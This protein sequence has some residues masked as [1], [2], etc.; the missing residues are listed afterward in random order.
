MGSGSSRISSVG[1]VQNG[2]AAGGDPVC[3]RVW[4][5]EGMCED[6]AEPLGDI[7]HVCDPP[8]EPSNALCPPPPSLCKC[9][10]MG[11]VTT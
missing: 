2:R 5:E 11:S 1:S 10:G 8:N 9:T 4:E 7:A 6:W 3:L